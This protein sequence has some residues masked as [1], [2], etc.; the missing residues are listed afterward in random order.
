M[1]NETAK[2]AP[3]LQERI[4]ARQAKRA[5]V[6]KEAQVRV[7]AAYT[8]AKTMLP[9]APAGIRKQFASVLLAADTKILK[10]ALRQTA[11]NAHYTKIAETLKEVHKVEMNQLLEAS[12]DL[13]K[14]KREVKSELQGDAKSASAKVADDREA[15]GPQPAKYNDGTPMSGDRE[16]K[17]DNR[18]DAEHAG[19]RK[20]DTVDKTEGG[21]KI[22]DAVQDSARAEKSASAKKAEGMGGS[23]APAAPVTTSAP[24]ASPVADNKAEIR[25][26]AKKAGEKCE[27]CG[28]TECKCP[29]AKESASEKEANFGADGKPNEGQVLQTRTQTAS[30]AKKADEMAPEAPAGDTSSAAPGA[31]PESAEAAPA[32]AEELKQDDERAVLKEKVQEAEQAV[33]AIEQQIDKEQAEEVDLTGMGGETPVAEGENLDM[34]DIFSDENLTEKASNLANEHHESADDDY[35][36]PSASS[37]LESSL[38]Q[39]QM[40]S[41]EDMFA[42]E[43]SADPMASLFEKSA[44]NVEGF[45]VV[46]SF[47][48]AANHFKSEHGKDDRDKETDH[49]EDILSL[50]TEN[51][52][53]Q[54]D[55]QER[56]SQDATPKLETPAAKEAAAKPGLKHIKASASAPATPVVNIADILFASIDSYDE[57]REARQVRR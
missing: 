46:N 55:D 37:E 7:A 3:S 33:Q 47:E 56:V 23:P 2:K 51:L 1:A 54:S 24:A 13:E 8:I 14:A 10:A 34:A 17:A 6:G 48:D 30:K 45:E 16:Y 15:A 21:E 18:M 35:F 57:E 27:K 12:G 53:E 43:A 26:S 38:D 40:A 50:L 11:I 19:E 22:E 52:S 28:M 9:S 41:L 20:A 44:A 42:H 32:A 25:A 36:G 29:A 4:A 39:P 49:D 31:G 5:E